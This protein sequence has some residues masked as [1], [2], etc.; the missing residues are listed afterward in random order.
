MQMS[1]AQAT[2]LRE[3][4][5]DVIEHFCDQHQL[6]GETAWSAVQALSAAKSFCLAG[7]TIRLT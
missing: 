2:E 6:S 7:S 1:R 4:V 3:L 5:E